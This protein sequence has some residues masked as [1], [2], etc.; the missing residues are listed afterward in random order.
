M[1]IYTKTGDDGTTGL[2][3]G[4]RVSKGSAR[5][6]AYGD[7]DELNAAI[8]AARAEKLPV[9]IDQTLREVQNR[10]FDLGSELATPTPS[11]GKAPKINLAL[12]NEDDV[13]LLERTIDSVD[14]T[15]PPLSAF[16]LPGGTRGAAL[17][18]VART[19]CRRAERHVVLLRDTQPV[20]DE[21]VHYLNRLSDALFTFSRGVNAAA[22]APDVEWQKKLP[23]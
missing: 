14:A 13:F 10:L 4:A 8:G 15:L 12:V 20:R 22:N 17:L 7:L 21:V 2:F 23:T 9:L 6:A 16:I 19:V 11:E 1:K 3:G 5:V 18:H